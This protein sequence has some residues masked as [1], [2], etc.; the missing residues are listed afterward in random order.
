MNKSL[1]DAVFDT[2]LQKAFLDAAD[3]ELQALELP[4]KVTYDAA[5]QKGE[6]KA[7]HKKVS[8][9]RKSFLAVGSVKKVAIVV[10]CLTLGGLIATVPKVGA[11]FRNFATTFYEKYFTIT[12]NNIP[13][14][15]TSAYDTPASTPDIPEGYTMD[16]ENF[17]FGYIPKDYTVFDSME[18]SMVCVYRFSNRPDVRRGLSITITALEATDASFDNE[19]STIEDIQIQGQDGYY[20]HFG[21]DDSYAIVWA[22][23]TWLYTVE[24]FLSK[25]EL[26]RVAENVTVKES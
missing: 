11:D 1:N 6:R 5:Y 7:Y 21:M 23:E 12:A 8:K 22:D 17:T 20:I 24:G 15:A 10:V 26:V 13:V 2:I 3:Q 14:D 19:N 18:N 25:E 9:R 4:E 16:T